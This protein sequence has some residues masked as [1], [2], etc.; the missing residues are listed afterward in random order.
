MN[1]CAKCGKPFIGFPDHCKCQQN[2]AFTIS[3]EN[4][5]SKRE[6]FA[7][8]AMQSLIVHDHSPEMDG[9]EVSYNYGLV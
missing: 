9:Y 7:A 4:F 2:F 5:M 1:N 8:M 3:P 6:Y